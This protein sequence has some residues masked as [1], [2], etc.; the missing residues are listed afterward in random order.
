MS[1]G[2]RLRS[3]REEK[4]WKQTYVAKMLGITSQSLSNYERGDRDP[5]TSLLARL[6]DLYDVTTDY[7]LGRDL[8][9]VKMKVDPEKVG[10]LADVDRLAGEAM[11]L[12]NQALAEGSI[13]EEQASLSLKLFR[14]S[15]LVMM[16]E[17]NK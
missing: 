9:D 2:D 8:I 12:L 13:S 14:Q 5:D 17:K 16:E 3:A 1:L 6:A 15:L 7:L 11:E 4:G 10:S